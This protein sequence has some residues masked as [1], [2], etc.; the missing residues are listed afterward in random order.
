MAEFLEKNGAYNDWKKGVHYAKEVIN[1]FKTEHFVADLNDDSIQEI[2]IAVWSGGNASQNSL[3]LIF[4]V[5]DKNDFP[6]G[7]RR[8]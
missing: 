7:G 3:A 1:L 8:F 5:K 2:A 4:S 6:F